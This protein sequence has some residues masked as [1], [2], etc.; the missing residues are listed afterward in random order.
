[1]GRRRARECDG[2]GKWST[3]ARGVGMGG[4]YCP[5]CDKGR[6]EP[7]VGNWRIGRAWPISRIDP[8]ALG[9]AGGP[10]PRVS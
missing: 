9:R 3:D 5:A 8:R 1:M 2:C 4:W 6:S 10:S 7:Y